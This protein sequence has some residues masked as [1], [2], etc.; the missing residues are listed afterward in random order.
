MVKPEEFDHF[1]LCYH[2]T[3][4]FKWKARNL[5]IMMS[6]IVLHKL[7][8]TVFQITQKPHSPRT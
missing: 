6:Q 5:I 3:V 7:F 1:H 4:P 2:F 8:N